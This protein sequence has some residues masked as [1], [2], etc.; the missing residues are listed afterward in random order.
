[1][2]LLYVESVACLSVSAWNAMVGLGIL[3]FFPLQ[4][5]T[6]LPCFYLYWKTDLPE[7][8]VK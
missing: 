4:P 1:M 2:S 6:S 7:D 3:S 8:T 5:Q